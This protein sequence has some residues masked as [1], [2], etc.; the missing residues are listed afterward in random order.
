MPEQ[1]L[2]DGVKG[3]I[4]IDC[5]SSGI[6]PILSQYEEAKIVKHIRIVANLGYGY[7]RQEVV[8]SSQEHVSL[9]VFVGNWIVVHCFYVFI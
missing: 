1:T 8:T 2:R 6:A 4:S 3:K 7:T 9:V 5:I